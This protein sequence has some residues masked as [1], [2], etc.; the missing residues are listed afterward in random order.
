M[1]RLFHVVVIYS[2]FA[3]FIALHRLVFCLSL[4]K[5]VDK[6]IRQNSYFDSGRQYSGD[7]KSHHSKSVNIQNLAS[8]KIRFQTVWFSKV[9]AIALA[10]AV[11]LTI[12]KPYHSKSEL[13]VMILNGWASGFQI[14]FEIRTIASQLLF[15]HSKSKLFLIREPCYISN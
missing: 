7:L 3:S 8:L 12:Q 15:D 9:Q 2:I 6:L 14:P 11:V 1:C 4:P 10:I 5:H 13:F